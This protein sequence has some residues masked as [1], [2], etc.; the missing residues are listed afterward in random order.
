MLSK[1]SKFA[2][3]KSANLFC[4]CCLGVSGF[5]GGFGDGGGMGV[6]L[7]GV[8]DS[9]AEWEILW[10]LT[11]D[12]KAGVRSTDG[13]RDGDLVGVEFE[14]KG[15]WDGG[16]MLVITVSQ[17]EVEIGVV[18]TPEIGADADG[19][20]EIVVNRVEMIGILTI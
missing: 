5:G 20:T 13:G 3:K 18:C 4:C 1:F 16:A 6:E 8:G 17:A 12:S 14:P 15:G 19:G 10:L 9:L 7:V 2:F 11:A